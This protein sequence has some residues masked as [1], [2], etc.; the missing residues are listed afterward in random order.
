MPMAT[1]SK[2]PSVR[3]KALASKI[4]WNQ[5]KK[6]EKLAL[7]EIQRQKMDKILIT[8]LKD[9][10]KHVAAEKKAFKNLSKALTSDG[11]EKTKVYRN[12]VIK[13]TSNSISR[14]IDMMSNAVSV[15][16]IEQKKSIEK[17]Y[18]LLMSRLWIRSANPAAFN[19]GKKERKGK[20][21][22]GKKKGHS[23]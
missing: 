17:Q 10:P 21:K 18:P 22:G 19:M 11:K 12:K 4:W 16:S 14:Q 6:I 2:D 1:D 15:L 8:Y 7:T 23:H 3:N 9:Q 13:A 5:K 20:K